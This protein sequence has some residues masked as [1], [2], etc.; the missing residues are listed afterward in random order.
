[1]HAARYYYRYNVISLSYLLTVST[2]SVDL[3]SSYYI[4]LC[5]AA[6][7]YFMYSVGDI[8]SSSG[9]GGGD[10]SKQLIE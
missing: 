9:D 4:L 10:S 2:E 6:W 8:S 7:N 5:Q 1:M 3:M